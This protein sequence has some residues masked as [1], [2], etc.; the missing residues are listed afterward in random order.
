VENGLS[1]A[2]KSVRK[3]EGRH[4]AQHRFSADFNKSGT[5]GSFDA[6]SGFFA[7]MGH[8]LNQYCQ[9]LLFGALS[10]AVCGQ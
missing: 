5:F 3:D 4:P 10:A 2:S 1:L 7:K 9:K 8:F 6:A